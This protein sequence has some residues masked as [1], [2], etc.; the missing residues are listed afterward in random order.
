MPPSSVSSQQ[1]A[2]P[3]NNIHLTISSQ[4]PFRVPS[5]RRPNSS[6]R[7]NTGPQFASTPRFVLSQQTPRS[8]AQVHG[9]DDL[10]DGDES[11]Q[12][13]P[14]AN[15]RAAKRD[16]DIRPTQRQKETIEDSDDELGYNG[17]IHRTLPDD[18]TGGPDL[19]SSPPGDAGELE[20]EFEA[21]FGPTTTRTKR[22]RASLDP[23]IPFTQRRKHNDDII[24]TELPLLPSI[25]HQQPSNPLNATTLASC[26]QPPRH[27]Q[28]PSPS[29]ALDHSPLL[30]R[31]RPP[32]N[33]NR[34]FVLPR[35]PSPSQAAE[36]PSAIPTPFS[37]SSHTLR[38]RGR[39][40]SAAPS[41]LP[42]GMAAEVRSWILE[43]STKRE[44]MHMNHRNNT[45]AGPDLQKYFLAVRIA[46]VR[47]SA[48]ASS[49]PLAFVRGKP[50][51]SLDDDEDASGNH[52]GSE[53]RTILLLG[54]PR[55]QPAGLSSQYPDASR[56]PGLVRG[57]LVGVHRGL[58]WDLD[59][60]DRLSGYDIPS[61]PDSDG[62][63]QS[64]T[65]TKWLVCMEWD[66]ISVD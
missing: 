30:H 53:M 32:R 3:N 61:E 58:V 29:Q 9:K 20:A 28:V 38:G 48:L 25:Q 17:G 47:Q 54:A 49:G 59:L 43:M 33:G 34:R 35:S 31:D 27:S 1:N 5:S 65:T 51:T 55:S 44:Q 6:A 21:L 37:P 66:L 24:Q 13:T 12:S 16:Q 41:Y 8:A 64:R 15:I 40:R 36:D 42:G 2:S 7:P 4:T 45:G 14:V 39:H 52:E 22:R 11:P 62:H 50:V 63:G 23:E 46:D 56:V 60:E 26:H 57:N 18:I 19:D 10:T